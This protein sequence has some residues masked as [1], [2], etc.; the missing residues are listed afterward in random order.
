MDIAHVSGLHAELAQDLVATAPASRSRIEAWGSR[1]AGAGTFGARA[2]VGHETHSLLPFKASSCA[3][4]LQDAMFE[5]GQGSWFSF[6]LGR[7]VGQL[8][9]HL[10]LRRTCD[11]W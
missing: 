11:V 3:A 10:Q 2:Y 6:T 7:V 5:T 4:D 1:L 8:S 9:L